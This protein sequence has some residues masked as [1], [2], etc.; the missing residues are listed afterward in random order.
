MV[1]PEPFLFEIDGGDV[2]DQ[3]GRSSYTTAVI[4]M[5]TQGLFWGDDEVDA[6]LFSLAS[7]LSS[8]VVYNISKRM[9]SHELSKLVWFGHKTADA[10]KRYN[11]YVVVWGRRWRTTLFVWDGVL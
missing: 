4:L 1:W 10:M 8:K 5:D 6:N 7:V 11:F 2:V 3:E 9:E